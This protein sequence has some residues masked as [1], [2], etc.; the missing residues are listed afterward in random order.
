[1]LQRTAQC[2]AVFAFPMLVILGV[3]GT[4]QMACAQA[5]SVKH[6]AVTKKH[7]VPKMTDAE[8]IALATSA[9]PAAIAKSATIVDMTDMSSAK[10]RQLRAGTNGWI[11]YAIVDEP[12]CLDKEW[13]KWMAAWTSKS[14][15]K[16]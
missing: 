12:M 16:V 15:L 13:Q 4:I 2:L 14:E 9:A 6:G 10:P 11:C 3:Q 5:P 8:K 7:A 1:M